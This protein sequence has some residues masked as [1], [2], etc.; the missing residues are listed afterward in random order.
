[1]NS[2]L[3]MDLLKKD[4]NGFLSLS[5]ESIRKIFTYNATEETG[6]RETEVKSV[7]KVNRRAK[8][9]ELARTIKPSD[10]NAPKVGRFMTSDEIKE[11]ADGLNQKV[12]TDSFVYLYD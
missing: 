5:D 7:A 8:A 10:A 11:Y 2:K 1:M 6:T 12:A 3:A 9:Q 4:S